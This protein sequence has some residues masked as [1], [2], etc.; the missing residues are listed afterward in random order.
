MKAVKI[1]FGVLAGLATLGY[2][3]QF[4][5]AVTTGDLSTQGTTEIVA[6][7]GVLC[8]GAAI[9][10]ALFRSASQGD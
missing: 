10:V 5:S 4:I 8:V 3:W 7:L 1:V 2:L 9:T 6:A